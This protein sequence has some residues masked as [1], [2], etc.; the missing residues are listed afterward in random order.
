M[1]NELKNKFSAHQ[2]DVQLK[3]CELPKSAI[4]IENTPLAYGETSGHCH[5]LTGDVQM[6]Q[7]GDTMYAAVGN[8]GAFLQHIHESVYAKNKATNQPLPIADHKPVQLQP[9]T[10]YVF[11]I[12]K[13]YNPFARVWQKVRD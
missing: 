13:R 10:T 9:N 7:D 8:D 3:S 12:H 6:Y 4:K 2:G 11:G 1:K 5:A